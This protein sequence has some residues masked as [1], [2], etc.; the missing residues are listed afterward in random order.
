MGKTINYVRKSITELEN[1]VNA[2]KKV[3]KKEKDKK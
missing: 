1:M 3:V 2:D